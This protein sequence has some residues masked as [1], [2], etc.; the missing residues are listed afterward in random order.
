MH[1]YPTTEYL[2]GSYLYQGCDAT[3][4][5]RFLDYLTPE[6][7][8]IVLMSDEMADSEFSEI[9]PWYGVRYSSQDIP[10]D[11]YVSWQSSTLDCGSFIPNIFVPTD[12][13][14]V[15][16][17]PD[18]PVTP[19]K[20]VHDETMEIWHKYD[21]KFRLPKCFVCLQLMVNQPSPSP[22]TYVPFVV[23]WINQYA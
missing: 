18:A 19:V 9:E 4:I 14:L 21:D 5:Q 23:I 2:T 17:P 13:S 6:N 11:W 20:I 7:T 8:F 15:D 22:D 12:F 10:D 3:V 16:L 1:L